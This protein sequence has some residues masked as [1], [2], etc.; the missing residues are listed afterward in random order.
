MLIQR[1]HK[2]IEDDHIKIERITELIKP[3][4][5]DISPQDQDELASLGLVLTRQDLIDA[6][7]WL[8]ALVL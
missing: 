1:A 5:D 8:N 7:R 2:S 6:Q 3:S 4:L